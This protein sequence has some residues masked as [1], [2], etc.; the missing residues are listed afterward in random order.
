MRAG[1]QTGRADIADQVPLFHTR[2]FRDTLRISFQ[3]QVARSQRPDIMFNFQRITATTA[4]ILVNHDAI[5]DR[6]HRSP[7][8]SGIIDPVVRAPDAQHRMQTRIRKTRADAREFQRGFE[9]S[10]AQAV[11]VF[12]P[13]TQFSILQERNRIIGFASMLETRA[14]NRPKADIRAV[15][16]FLVVNYRKIILGL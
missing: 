16:I 5:A 13:I 9:Q 8:R 3:V 1:C 10:F 11:T 15:D 7:R 4:P 12:V 6:V 2:A 14:P